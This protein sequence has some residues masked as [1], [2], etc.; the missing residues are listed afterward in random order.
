MQSFAVRG[1]RSMGSMQGGAGGQMVKISSGGSMYGSGS[2]M[3]GSG[4]GGGGGGGS[5]YGYSYSSS[6]GAGF[7]FGA[8]GGAGGGGGGGCIDISANEKAA[9]QNLN[10]RL[11]SYLEKVRKLEAANA[12]L[13]LKI[14][15]FLEQKT[16]PSARDYSAY[17]VTIAELQGKIQD[18]TKVNGAIYLAIDNAKLAADDFRVKYENELAM[19]LSVE[20]DIAGLRR[21]LDELTLN[22]TD[23]EMQIEGLKEELIFLKKN[24]EEELL[25]MRAQMSGQVNVEVDAA[26]A[27]DLAKIIDESRE[28]YES[29]AAKSKKDLE[30]WFQQKTETLKQEVAA[31]TQTIQ[32]SKSEITE[33]KRTLQALEIELQSQLSMKA[34]LEGTLA[35][36]Q[37]RYAMQLAGYQNQVTM[38]EEQ[39]MQLRADLERQ[40]QEYQMLLDIKTRLE[41][42]IAEYRR[43]LDGE[44]G[45]GISS[46][47]SS[48][49]RS[50]SSTSGSGS[51][52]STSTTTSTTK[53]ITIVEE[54]VDGKVVSSSTETVSQTL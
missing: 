32:T 41:M 15:Q 44:G 51:G 28:H 53:V 25:A 43:L 6:G 48:T 36:T 21:V 35:E 52:G 38:L 19:R 50:S 54:V 7:G 42:E 30:V 37:N 45:G 34:S 5:S 8:G 39:L 23:L 1:V 3:F 40:S 46:S 31:D 18:A 11:A 26:P 4:G 27:V 20:S 33:L 47:S 29:I 12:E 24:H 13:E 16:S 2:S 9:M 10:D 17:F 49:V 22:R 14:R